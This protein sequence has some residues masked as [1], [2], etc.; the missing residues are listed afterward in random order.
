M[1]RFDMN[2]N[3]LKEMTSDELVMVAGGN[4]VVGGII[5]GI[6]GNYI[7]DAIGGAEG[8]NSFF[9]SWGGAAHRAAQRQ[10]YMRY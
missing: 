1:E 7:Y 3:K 8:I 9:N 5:G 2:V 10:M 6:I 4:P